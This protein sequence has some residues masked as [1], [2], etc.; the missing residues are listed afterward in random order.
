[1]PVVA[2]GDGEL[3]AFLNQRK[4]RD[5]LFPWLKKPNFE[6]PKRFLELLEQFPA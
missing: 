4:W 1:M 5:A 6:I 2:S 3:L